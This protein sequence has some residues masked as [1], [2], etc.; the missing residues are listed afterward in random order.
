MCGALDYLEKLEDLAAC[1]FTWKQFAGPFALL[2]NSLQV[3]TAPL[4]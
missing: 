2:R 1:S 4:L 3:A